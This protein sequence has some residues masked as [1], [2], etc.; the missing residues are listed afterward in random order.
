MS[1]TSGSG[2]AKQSARTLAAAYAEI[3]K[4]KESNERL[5][6]E[7]QLL[8]GFGTLIN[9]LQNGLTDVVGELQPLRDLA[10][11]APGNTQAGTPLDACASN[12]L[13]TLRVSLD[14]V[15]SDSYD[16]ALDER[17]VGF[18]HD[19]PGGPYPCGPI[20]YETTGTGEL[21]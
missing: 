4:L 16:I 13:N 5:F 19:T 12:R 20:L 21:S 11:S 14:R 15:K 6:E 17:D 18:L 10:A 8:G 7:L 2:A 1:D 9:V 3:D